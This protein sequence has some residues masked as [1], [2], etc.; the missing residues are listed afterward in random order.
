MEMMMEA[1]IGLEVVNVLLLLGLLAIYVQNY[2]KLKAKF[3]LGLIFFASLFV[4]QN[5]VSL[6]WH[7]TLPNEMIDY[8]KNPTFLI[9]GIETVGLMVLFLITWKD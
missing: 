6:A 7:I 3:T 8:L 4:L 5:L 2:R 9:S 1:A